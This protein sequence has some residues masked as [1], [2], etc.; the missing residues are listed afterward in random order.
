MREG[1]NNVENASFACLYTQA[2]PT[3]GQTERHELI[4]T[5]VDAC[6]ESFSSISTPWVSFARHES[7]RFLIHLFKTQLYSLLQTGKHVK[8]RFGAGLVHRRSEGL[9]QRGSGLRRRQRLDQVG[10]RG[11]RHV[12]GLQRENRLG[13]TLG[14]STG[15]DQFSVAL[16]SS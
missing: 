14:N 1:L 3:D 7:K 8:L 5:C 16:K 12:H 11:T 13:K 4:R 2:R 9:Q 15:D 10:S 6:K